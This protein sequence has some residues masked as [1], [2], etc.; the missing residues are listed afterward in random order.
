MNDSH[1]RPSLPLVPTMNVRLETASGKNQSTERAPL[2]TSILPMQRPLSD[3]PHR[4]QRYFGESKYGCRAG[5]ESVSPPNKEVCE[6][7]PQPGAGD[8]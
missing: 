7:S 8:G 6:D 4:S 2:P 3:D 5:D 1:S